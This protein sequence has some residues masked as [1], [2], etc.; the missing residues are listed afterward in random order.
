[1]TV[2][3]PAGTPAS[4]IAQARRAAQSSGFKIVR[5]EAG[6]GTVGVPTL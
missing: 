1:M 2:Q 3:H 4:C 5:M 6:D